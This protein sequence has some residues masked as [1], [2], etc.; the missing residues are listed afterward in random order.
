MKQLVEIQKQGQHHGNTEE[1]NIKKVQL[2]DE[3]LTVARDLGICF[4]D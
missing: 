3:L 2:D 4:G 1:S